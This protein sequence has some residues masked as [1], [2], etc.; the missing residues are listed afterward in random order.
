M[1]TLKDLYLDQLQDLYSADKQSLEA[2]KKLHEVATSDELKTALKNGVDGISTGRDMLE[3]M[4][5]GHDADP[6][7]E[8]CKGMEGLVKEV[9]DHALDASFGDDDLRDA[10]II[11]QYQRMT[12]YGIAGYGCCIAFARRLGFEEDAKKLETALDNTYKGDREMTRI[13]EGGVNAAAQAA[14]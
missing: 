13:A 8:H 9:H 11:T 7:G 3:Q 4:I 6:S 14:E 10:M 5:K 2:T 1:D 12:H